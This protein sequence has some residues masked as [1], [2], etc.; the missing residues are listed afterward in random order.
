MAWHDIQLNKLSV[1]RT[2]SSVVLSLKSKQHSS[3][4]IEKSSIGVLDCELT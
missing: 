3:S 2:Y 4:Q 1:Y